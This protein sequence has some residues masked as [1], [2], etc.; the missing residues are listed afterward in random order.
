VPTPTIA[1]RE[2]EP[3]SLKNCRNVVIENLVFR[4][5]GKDVIAIHLDH[6]RNVTVRNVVFIRVAEGVYAARS[7]DIEVL[8]SRYEDITGPSKRRKGK[9]VA[10][11]VQFNRVDGGRI[12][13]NVGRGGDTE[14]IVSLYKTS[15]VVVE[16]NHFEGIDWI[17]HSGS[18]IALGDNGGHDN[19]ARRNILINPGQAGVFIAGGTG[20][21][22]VDNIVY[23][24]QRPR[25]NVG[26]YVWNQHDEPCSGNAVARNRVSWTTEDGDPNPFWNS[27]DCGRVRG[28]DT[29][30]FETFDPEP[31]RVPPLD[32]SLAE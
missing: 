6:C 12:A 5:L 7:R 10:N 23:G 31:Y 25:S 4:D 19:T 17:S 11:F 24:E 1:Y 15:N 26:M 16:D 9:N 22:I 27:G 13:R 28:E 18:G 20:H 29:N 14:D 2:S 21:R 3:I 8:D 30:S 32:P